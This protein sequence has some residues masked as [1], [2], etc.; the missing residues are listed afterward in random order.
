[1]NTSKYLLIAL[2]AMALSAIAEAQDAKLHL[3]DFT[4][5][6]KIDTFQV[7]GET[8]SFKR[9]VI[10]AIKTKGIKSAYWDVNVAILT[11]QYNEKLI[12]LSS[13]KSLFASEMLLPEKLKRKEEMYNALANCCHW[14][15]KE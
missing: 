9:R 11:V 13:I 10:D 4:P 6:Y 7:K 5:K 1:M 8:S 3:R 14:K 15:N 2:V 12:S